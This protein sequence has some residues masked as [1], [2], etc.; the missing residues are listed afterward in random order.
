MMRAAGFE[1]EKTFFKAVEAGQIMA[2]D[3][4]PKFG[5][6]L[7]K[8]AREGGALE[9]V[10]KKTRAEMNR[11]FNSLTFAKDTIFQEGMDEGLAYMF[12][13]FSEMIKDSKPALEF[14]GGWF[15]GTFM[16]IV[17]SIQ[18]ATSPIREFANLLGNVFGSDGATVLGMVS[19]GYLVVRT[20][21]M[22]GAAIPPLVKMLRVLS[23]AWALSP[24]GVI[25]RLGMLAVGVGSVYAINSAFDKIEGSNSGNRQSTQ[26]NVKVDV[27]FKTE[28]ARR[29]VKVEIDNHKTSEFSRLEG[30]MA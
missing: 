13:T 12:G 30:E 11:F 24:M 7:S 6:E 5:K 19:G 22:I 21:T 20:L 9:A 23:L 3:V 15:K 1:D 25:S 4:L 26:Q 2:D 14:L 29:F 18:I 27:D 16:S 10:T 17:K 28:D 8:M